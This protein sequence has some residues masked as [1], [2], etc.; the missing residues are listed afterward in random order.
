VSVFKN[1]LLAA[2][3]ELGVSVDEEP[4]WKK[5]VNDC[6]GQMPQPWLLILDDACE[7]VLKQLK[8]ILPE[9]GAGL[10]LINTNVLPKCVV[11][12]LD[13]E[14]LPCRNMTPKQAVHLLRNITG[15][16]SSEDSAYE[17]IAKRCSYLPFA[18][19]MAGACIKNTKPDGIFCAPEIY[20][21]SFESMRSEVLTY[22]EPGNDSKSSA[23]MVIEASIRQ[24]Q[25]ELDDACATAKLSVQDVL[26]LLSFFL[27]ENLPLDIMPFNELVFDTCDLNDSERLDW[28]E[29]HVKWV[30]RHVEAIAGTSP[31]SNWSSYSWQHLKSLL[32]KYHL[33]NDRPCGSTTIYSM[34]SLLL[35]WANDTMQD[36]P[37]LYL[38][39]KL[40]AA[41]I[42]ASARY[43]RART[44]PEQTVLLSRLYPHW[45]ACRYAICGSEASSID[46]HSPVFH[47]TLSVPISCQSIAYQDL[48]FEEIEIFKARGRSRD[49][50][51]PCQSLLFTR[52]QQTDEEAIQRSRTQLGECREVI[53]DHREAL[54]LRR[55]VLE[56]AKRQVSSEL[57]LPAILDLAKSFTKLGDYEKG[58]ML[59]R[60]VHE[61][62]LG[63][64]N[65][66]DR[67]HVMLVKK[68]LG[69]VCQRTGRFK[70]AIQNRKDV[71]NYFH[72]R[73]YL[74]DHAEVIDAKTNLAHSYLEGSDSQRKNAHSLYR[75]VAVAETSHGLLPDDHPR[76]LI[77]LDNLAW[78]LILAD[79]Q[80]KLDEARQILARVLLLR[81]K[82]SNG[83]DVRVIKVRI[84]L[85]VCDVRVG[86]FDRA[87]TEL[88]DCLQ[89]PA[90]QTGM[91][92]ETRFWAMQE[93]V[94]VL[95]RIEKPALLRYEGLAIQI[96]LYETHLKQFGHNNPNMIRLAKRV[97]AALEQLGCWQAALPYRV[98]VASYFRKVRKACDEESL[99]AERHLARNLSESPHKA[100]QNHATD[101]FDRLLI[102]AMGQSALNFH[103]HTSLAFFVMP[104]IDHFKTHELFDK[105]C[106][107]LEKLFGTPSLLARFSQK[108]VQHLEYL[109]DDCRKRVVE[110][111]ETWFALYRDD[112][113]KHPIQSELEQG[114]SGFPILPV[115]VHVMAVFEWER[116]A[117]KFDAPYPGL[118]P[119]P[120]SPPTWKPRFADTERVDTRHNSLIAVLSLTEVHTRFVTP[121]PQS[122]RLMFHRAKNEVKS[123]TAYLSVKMRKLCER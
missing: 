95:F 64:H 2:F 78:S 90:L 9:N 21:R 47:N 118:H 50:I 114:C 48:L 92:D 32:R 109:L 68:R 11:P 119:L 42:L 71:L 58:Y 74:E 80:E 121:R 100:H 104:C 46:D 59:L 103:T 56:Y 16:C 70:E 89:N 111:P 83:R 38:Q 77:A 106:L 116:R 39:L 61:T 7:H 115:S 44:Q 81:M 18:L 19:N 69:N 10:V 113:A 123:A 52:V 23:G 25:A 120:P 14:C 57:L 86:E 22:K 67:D 66:H 101:L 72:R 105:G 79:D 8:D 36:H 51:G 93:L 49:V 37:D 17:D 34:H 97:A 76:L 91:E 28:M 30:Q 75:Q 4:A 43:F 3:P 15:D 84:K 29:Q 94:D 5:I 54:I 62:A 27:P 26:Q 33:L 85:A 45:Q 112:Q 87:R 6:L 110:P 24:V 12:P 63:L 96:Y 117:R 73:H 53:G 41:T 20:V 98:Q 13:W 35:G 122:Q 82:H 55:A 88:W 40:T 65:I 1:D 102:H 108:D 60:D 99:R 107:L 31:C